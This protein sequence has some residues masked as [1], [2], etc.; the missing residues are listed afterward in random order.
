MGIWNLGVLET[1]GSRDVSGVSLFEI[2]R[3]REFG[4]S[5][6]SNLGMHVGGLGFLIVRELENL[7]IWICQGLETRNIENLI[8]WIFQSLECQ[9]FGSKA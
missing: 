7:G 3:S 1:R 6:F 4:D 2:R 8:I 9:S 5:I